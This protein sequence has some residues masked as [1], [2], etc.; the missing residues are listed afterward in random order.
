MSSC[1]EFHESDQTGRPQ[2]RNERAD[3]KN[4]LLISLAPQSTGHRVKQSHRLKLLYRPGIRRLHVS[5]VR[6]KTI[7]FH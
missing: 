2:E 6:L 4:H 3:A 1:L 7:H 5:D